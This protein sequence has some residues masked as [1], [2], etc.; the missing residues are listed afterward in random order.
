MASISDVPG[1]TGPHLELFKAAGFETVHSLRGVSSTEILVVLGRVNMQLGIAE[2]LP[3]ETAIK[4]W[5]RAAVT[6]ERS[7]ERAR[8]GGT[9]VAVVSERELRDAGID[10]EAVPVARPVAKAKSEDDGKATAKAKPRPRSEAKPKRVEKA[11]RQETA[12]S[13][14]FVPAEEPLSPEEVRGLRK[15]SRSRRKARPAKP[16]RPA[17]ASDANPESKGS[18]PNSENPPQPI[19]VEENVDP[20][21]HAEEANLPQAEPLSTSEKLEQ[22]PVYGE[23]EVEPTPGVTNEFRS[24]EEEQRTRR[25]GER[26]NRGMSHPD[27]PRVFVGALVTLVVPAVCVVVTAILASVLLMARFSEYE[28][29]TGIAFLLLVYPI[30]LFLYL[31]LGTKARCRLCGQKLFVPKHCRKHERAARSIFGTTYAMA[32]N[33]VTRASYR[34]QFCGTKTRLKK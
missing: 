3:S 27:A 9:A 31:G 14:P 30:A 1:L 29:P 10:V 32:F 4:V 23:D 24:L 28:P 20:P 13:A 16:A 21:R 22:P 25:Q 6:L 12:E 15:D 26:R 18:L 19:P 8:G 34:C 11:P 7:A 17:P 2:R 33:V 5:Q